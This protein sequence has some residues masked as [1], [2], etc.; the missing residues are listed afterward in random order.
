MDNLTTDECRRIARKFGMS[1]AAYVNLYFLPK[2][3]LSFGLA[4]AVAI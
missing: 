3:R 1:E 2:T 4:D